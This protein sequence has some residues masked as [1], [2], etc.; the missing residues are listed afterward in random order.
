MKRFSVVARSD[1]ADCSVKLTYFRQISIVATIP[2]A[3]PA[4]SMLLADGLYC[5]SLSRIQIYPKYTCFVRK[6]EITIQQDCH[7][8]QMREGIVTYHTRVARTGAV[9]YASMHEV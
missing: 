6:L 7:C 1:D 2:K 5:R 3:S 8:D 9:C 4:A